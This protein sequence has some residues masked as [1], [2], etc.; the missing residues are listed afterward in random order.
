MKH[1]RLH[2]DN[3]SPLAR[4]SFILG[5]LGFCGGALFGIPA[6]VCGHLARRRLRSSSQKGDGLAITGL[7]LG[8]LSFIWTAF[9][10]LLVS[11]D[12]GMPEKSQLTQDL[13]H[14]RTMFGEMQTAASQSNGVPFPADIGAITKRGYLK[15]LVDEAYL[16]QADS[17]R[18]SARLSIGNISR[19]DPPETITL[20]SK[21]IDGQKSGFVILQMNG[22]GRVLRQ[23]NDQ[24]PEAKDPPR[25]PAYLP[26]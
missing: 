16:T 24:L 15:K 13:H 10:M 18:L 22:E 23:E 20:R 12:S 4:A 7:I 26:D 3:L 1:M 17:D 2:A 25:T 5:M 6:I 9:F 8:Y 14:A 21:P 19:N 11:M